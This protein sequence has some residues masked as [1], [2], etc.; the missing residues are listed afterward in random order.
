MSRIEEIALSNLTGTSE[1]APE[2][3][4]RFA[5]QREIGSVMR[6]VIADNLRRSNPHDRGSIVVP[7][8]RPE[9][10]EAPRGMPCGEQGQKIIEDLCNAALP[11]ASARLGP[12]DQTQ[13]LALIVR[14]LAILASKQ[15]PEGPKAT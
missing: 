5:K 8:K 12:Q 4:E 11:P 14:L 13:V 15:G 7:L 9:P 3:M 2:R 1:S 6:D 10:V